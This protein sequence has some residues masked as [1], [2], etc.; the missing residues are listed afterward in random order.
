MGILDSIKNFIAVPE[1]EYDDELDLEEEEEQDEPKKKIQADAPKR[2]EGLP[3]LIGGKQR[4][5][6][7]AP[8]MKVVI[9]KPRRYDEVTSIADNLNERKSVILNLEDADVDLS[10]RIVDFLSGAAYANHGNI[11]K[12]AKGSFLI[13]PN[14]VDMMGEVMPDD[15]DDTNMYF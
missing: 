6:Q 12:I 10:R 11:R 15:F 7:E 9:V 14:G 3:R 4:T 5:V 1:E 8:A 2:N 13:V